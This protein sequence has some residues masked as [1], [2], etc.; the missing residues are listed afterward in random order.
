MIPYTEQIIVEVFTKGVDSLGTP[1]ESWATLATV[2]ASVSQN[3]GNK[4]YDND[5]QQ[6][7]HSFQTTFYT[8]Y[9]ENLS[10]LCR[11]KCAAETYTIQSINT[12][13]RR[14]GHVIICERNMNNGR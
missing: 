10:Y 12:T 4:S 3:S 1:T 6:Q 8:R 2:R 9:I 5:T 11:I 7:S 13:P 14:K